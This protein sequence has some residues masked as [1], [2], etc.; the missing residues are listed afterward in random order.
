MTHETNDSRPGFNPAPNPP[1]VPT[2]PPPDRSL[3]AVP[4]ANPR[5]HGGEQ[6]PGNY[7]RKD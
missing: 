2:A 7:G 1:A 6:S 4:T 5:P 3:N